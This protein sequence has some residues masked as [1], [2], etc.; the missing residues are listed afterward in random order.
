MYKLEDGSQVK[1]IPHNYNGIATYINNSS[2][3]WYQHGKRH[4]VD[5]HAWE[6]YNG[7]KAW[8]HYGKCHRVNGP[9]TE[10][11]DGRKEWWIN[12]KQITKATRIVCL[13]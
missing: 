5:G 11:C 2:K 1:I 7:S 6:S 10:W 12:G 8:Y 4:R 9:A 13:Y 3:A